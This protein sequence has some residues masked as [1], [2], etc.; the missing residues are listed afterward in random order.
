MKPN[1]G[2]QTNGLSKGPFQIVLE[3]MEGSSHIWKQKTNPQMLKNLPV[4]FGDYFK[5]KSGEGPEIK[6]GAQLHLYLT[7]SDAPGDTEQIID[8]TVF[9]LDDL[10]VNRTEEKVISFDNRSGELHLNLTLSN[11]QYPRNSDITLKDLTD[12]KTK[13]IPVTP[14]SPNRLQK[15]EL[16]ESQSNIYSLPKI[17]VRFGIH[18]HTGDGEQMRIVGSDGKLGSWDLYKAPILNWDQGFWSIEITFRRSYLPLEY[19]YVVY[20][21]H[22]GQSRWEQS[23]NR[24]LDGAFEECLEQRDV[25]DSVQ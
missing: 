24:K 8:S 10:R 22:T 12:D 4:L 15:S 1:G 14:D 20:N 7:K 25:W 19:K 6:A 16:T 13:M 17:T 23:A 9:S 11:T 21:V 3:V 2:L 18:Y 5:V